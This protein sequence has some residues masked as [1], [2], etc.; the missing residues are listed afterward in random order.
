MNDMSSHYLALDC[1]QPNTMYKFNVSNNQPT[2]TNRNPTPTAYVTDGCIC[3]KD[4]ILSGKECVLESQC[5][6]M[7]G[8]KY[9][10]VSWVPFVQTFEK[11]SEL[12]ICTFFKNHTLTGGQ[13]GIY[14][15]TEIYICS[16]TYIH[17]YVYIHVVIEVYV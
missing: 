16:N 10:K 12:C 17:A 2:C 11:Y 7:Y 15:R 8:R 9:L 5:G 6:C 13:R 1:T 14:M 3:K 4:Y